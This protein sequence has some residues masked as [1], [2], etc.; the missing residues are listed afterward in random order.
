[1]AKKMKAPR[2]HKAHKQ[3]KATSRARKMLRDTV[4]AL[5]SAEQE[6]ERQVKSLLKKNKINMDEAAEMLKQFRSRV[7]KE[8]K[9]G[10]RELE[11]RLKALQARVKKERHHVAKLAAEGVQSALAAL[12]IPSRREVSELTHKVDE[13]SKKIDRLRRK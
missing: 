8:R 2:A 10:A 3:V 4:D 7:D 6:V 5:T 9:K 1:M 11:A 13:L 12:N